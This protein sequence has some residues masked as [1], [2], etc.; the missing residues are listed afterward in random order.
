MGAR[1]RIFAAIALAL[2]FAPSAH[3]GHG[4]PAAEAA[5]LADAVAAGDAE[6]ALANT[7]MSLQPQSTSLAVAAAGGDRYRAAA[8][9][10]RQAETFR[11]QATDL[12]SYLMLGSDGDFLGTSKGGVE[13]TPEPTPAADWKVDYV[14]DRLH[15]DLAECRQVAGARPRRQADPGRAG[16]GGVASTSPP[17]SAALDFPEAELNLVGKPQTGPTAYDEVTRPGRRP[18]RT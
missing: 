1:S 6:Y 9:M 5:A 17:P 11:M 8:I 7:C 16:R 2:A 3:A 15:A 18:H 4:D 13:A 12:G 10:P 14:G